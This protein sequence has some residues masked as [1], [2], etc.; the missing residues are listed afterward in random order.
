MVSSAAGSRVV[1]LRHSLPDR[2]GSF[3]QEA[4]VH[5]SAEHAAALKVVCLR[6]EG[7]SL[8]VPAEVPEEGRIAASHDGHR[9]PLSLGSA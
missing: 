9:L 2:Q 1:S 7:R 6:R 5:A 8:F 3:R 4:A